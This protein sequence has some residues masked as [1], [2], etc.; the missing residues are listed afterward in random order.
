ME[1]GFR[2][3]IPLKESEGIPPARNKDVYIANE[4]IR[5]RYE[6]KPKQIQILNFLWKEIEKDDTELKEVTF[7]VTEFCDWAGIDRDQGNNYRDIRNAAKGLRDKVF[8]LKLDGEE[9]DEMDVGWV[10]T[11]WVK[12]KSG[13]IKIRLDEE[14]TKYLIGVTKRLKSAGF[15]KWE[16]FWILGLESKYSLRL[17]M[18]FQS[19]NYSGKDV[20]TATDWNIPVVYEIQHLK[21]QLMIENFKSYENYSKFNSRVLAPAIAEINEKSDLYIEYHP[22][23]NT[24]TRKQYNNVVF[25]IREKDGAEKINAIK[26]TNEQ[27]SG[28]P[29]QQHFEQPPIILKN[30]KSPADVEQ[31]PETVAPDSGKKISTEELIE[32][33]RQ[34]DSILEKLAELFKGKEGDGGKNNE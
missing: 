7:T 4:L 8:T 6:L 34:D 21:E 18:L 3:S 26:K 30:W 24:K 16:V 20:E 5:A 11:T 25:N 14:L 15:S 19:Y 12:E 1:E 17:Y 10:W 29:E 2:L 27:L 13:T 22:D 32:A 23:E 33:I 28:N 9:W 31:A